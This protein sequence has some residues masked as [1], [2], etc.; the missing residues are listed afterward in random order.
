MKLKDMFLMCLGNLFKHKIM[1]TLT[2]AGVVIGTSFIVV[3]VSLGI[4]I[5]KTMDDMIQG[6]GDLTVI[7]VYNWNQ[8]PDKDPL[9]DK[10]LE[11]F[12]EMDGVLAVTPSQNFSSYSLQIMSGK[13]SYQGQIYGVYMDS[14][15]DFGYAMEEGSLPGED[16]PETAVLFGRE[17]LYNFINTKKKSN[18]QVY[19][20]PDATGKIPDPYVDPMKDKLEMVL[21]KEDASGNN[22]TSKPVKLTGIGLMA[23]DY[24][25]N[26]PP[27]YSVFMDVKFL[28]KMTAEYN[29][30]NNIKV[31][32]TQ[33]DNY[34]SAL[35]KVDSLENVEAVNTAIQDLGYD[36][37][38][39]E[40]WRKSLQ[41]QTNMMQMILGCIGG[42][43][44]LVAALGIANTMIMSIYERTHEIGVMKVLG[45]TVGNI[46]AMFLMEA[47]TIGFIGGVIGNAFSFG[48]S[49]IVNSLAANNQN[50][51]GFL[52]FGMGGG[53]ISIIPYWLVLGALIFATL[54][55][56]VSGFYPANRAV[57]IS[58]LTAIKEE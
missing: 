1:T 12:K 39:M 50:G 14:L 40:S 37:N 34:E 3:M 7:Q 43:A 31:D 42:V 33:K 18:N 32:K 51:G 10:M 17:A 25:K 56:L 55:G 49:F 54:I 53:Q 21:R 5:Q 8:T 19:N 36:T 27:S 13:Y 41:D 29:K 16:T 20:Q 9:D 57:K 2:I 48:V 58:A 4:G 24:T 26:P 30:L 15:K 28:K 52:F 23:E 6:M 45:C 44:L 38:S 22:K 35:V 47:G 46:R 11:K